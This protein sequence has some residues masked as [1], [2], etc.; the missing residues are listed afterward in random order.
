MTEGP[1]GGVCIVRITPEVEKAIADSVQRALSAAL[2]ATITAITASLQTSLAETI[3]NAS[4]H[5][6][7]MNLPQEWVDEIGHLVG[8]VVDLGEGDI[9][10]GAEIVRKHHLWT[11]WRTE[12]ERAE[13]YESNHK[14][15]TELGYDGQTFKRSLLN[16]LA[17][18]L[19]GALAAGV[20]AHF[21]GM[22]DQ[23]APVYYINPTP[24]P[25][26][27]P[28]AQLPAGAI[29]GGNP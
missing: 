17:A 19:L 2:P 3:R 21:K 12:P 9:R 5:E 7:I 29:H 13:R 27:A 23:K 22:S 8:V 15:I 6:C 1:E 16:F 18:A 26:A 20:G 10:R 28:A 24:A 11:K 25:T 14:R 4:S